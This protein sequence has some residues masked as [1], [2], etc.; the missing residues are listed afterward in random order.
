MRESHALAGILTITL[1][2]AAG[3]VVDERKADNLI[4]NAGRELLGR[5]W[6][7]GVQLDASSMAI[8]IGTGDAPEKVEDT[9]LAA[10]V[11]AAAASAA[12]PVADG[13]QMKVTV[14]ATHKG[15]GLAETQ[16]VCEAGIE[17]TAAGGTVLYNRVTFPPINRTPNLDMTLS[18]EVLF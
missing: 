18:W 8:A 12:A 7:G 11:A 2:D 13:A 9:A 4:T 1:R 14:T 3:R 6:T 17:L 16:K 10:R 15:A 5:L